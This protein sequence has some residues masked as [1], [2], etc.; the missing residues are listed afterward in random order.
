MKTEEEI[1]NTEEEAFKAV[2]AYV[3]QEAIAFAKFAMD[4]TLQDMNID[5]RWSF[6]DGDRNILEKTDEELYSLYLQSKNK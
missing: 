5:N 3:M 2:D 6:E 4:K 1:F